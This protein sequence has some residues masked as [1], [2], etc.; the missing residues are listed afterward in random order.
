MARGGRVVHLTRTAKLWT[1]QYAVLPSP[2]ELNTFDG[3]QTNLRALSF[4]ISFAIFPFSFQFAIGG[5]SI[6]LITLQRCS[7]MLAVS[8]VRPEPSKA[9]HIRW[10]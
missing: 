2:L 9:E 5:L 7:N 8:A 4:V 3:D 6:R 10:R 1:L